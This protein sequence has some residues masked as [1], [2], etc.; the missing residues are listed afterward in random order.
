MGLKPVV[1]CKAWLSHNILSKLSVPLL[2]NRVT[3]A[4]LDINEHGKYFYLTRP[5]WQAFLVRIG[6]S[7]RGCRTR[8]QG[9]NLGCVRLGNL[10]LDFK[11]RIS[12]FQS[13]AKSEKGFQR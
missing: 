5:A 13:N 2:E 10:D 8:H 11:I 12:D 1:R 3:S 4:V 6:F 7:P 9:C